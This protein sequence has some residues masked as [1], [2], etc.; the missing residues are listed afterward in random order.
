MQTLPSLPPK[1]VARFWRLELTH[2]PRLTPARRVVRTI[3]LGMFKIIS[4]FCL[5]P[6]MRGLENL[7][8]HGP[9]LIV[10]NHLGDA[11][12][13]LLA[14]AFSVAPDALGKIELYSFPIL[15]KLMAWYGIIWLHRGQP[16][17]RALRAA[18]QGLAEGR[19]IVIAP[20]GRYSSIGGLEPGGNGAAFLALKANVPIIPVALT[21]TENAR[22]YGYLR[23]WQRAPVTLTAGVPFRLA[24]HSDRQDALRAGTHHTMT[25]LAGLL[26]AEYRGVYR[27][28][29]I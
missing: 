27:Q 14:A 17:R 15:G 2:L 24:N 16:D 22:V 6:S 29:E 20:E 7:P 13:A 11:D 25:V 23:R 9:A 5:K 1:P 19:I 10:V 18:L 28:P 12:A 8:R 21:G 26:P 3:I 4:F